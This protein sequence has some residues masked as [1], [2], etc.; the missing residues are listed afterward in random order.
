M[1]GHHP[2]E[3]GIGVRIPA[4]QQIW[5]VTGKVGSA[6]LCHS[7]LD[8][9]NSVRDCPKRNSNHSDQYTHHYQNNI[10]RQNIN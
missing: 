6:P 3:V 5:N 8:R 2:L 4:R 9:S 10:Y 1:V 7:K